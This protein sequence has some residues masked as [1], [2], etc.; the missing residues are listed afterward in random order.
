MPKKIRITKKTVKEPDEFVSVSGMA[1]EYIRNN[2]RNIV[3]MAVI[4]VVI[5]LI[6]TAW[7]YY[8]RG[9][10]K[11]AVLLFNQSRQFYLS[12]SKAPDQ[13]PV[14]ERYQKALEQFENVTKKY[15][16]TSSAIKS[17]IYMGDCS[18]HLGKYDQ[19]IE[20]YTTFINKSEKGNYLRRSV[21][22]SLGYCYEGKGNY[23]QALNYFKQSLDEGTAGTH[24]LTYLDIAR[25]YEALNDREHALEFYK[26][27]TD[28]QSGS[29][30]S[31]LAQER[32][33]AL[34]N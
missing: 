22:E 15:S 3:P 34:K 6:A 12:G 21:L 31:A 4:V 7:T 24:E 17:L 29:I 30:F 20:Y 1:A 10:E 27:Y 14:A 28:S 19:A 9:R 25:C 18:Y 16:G 8:S 33:E 23:E 2:Y 26:K 32:I 5:A 13:Q 11:D